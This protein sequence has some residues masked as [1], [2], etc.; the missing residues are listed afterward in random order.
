MGQHFESIPAKLI[1][2]IERQKI[3]WVATA[4]LAEDGHVNVSPKGCF[5][6][7][8]N[9]I[10]DEEDQG[11][12]KNSRAVWYE[13]LSGSGASLFL[14]TPLSMSLK[15]ICRGGDHRASTRERPNYGHVHR[16]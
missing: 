10:L 14:P 13:D 4:P 7:T 12:K 2:F 16:V 9:V 8:L 5:E 11:E 3:F 6:K 1:P 15:R